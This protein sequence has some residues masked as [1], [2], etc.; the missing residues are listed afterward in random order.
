MK[1]FKKIITLGLS[2]VFVVAIAITS[3]VIFGNKNRNN[4]R[5]VS[6]VEESFNWQDYGVYFASAEEETGASTAPTTMK[7]GA[8]YIGPGVDFNVTAGTFSNHEA[9]Y[10]GAFFVDNGATLNIYGGTIKSNGAMY[11]GAIY[12][13]EGGTLNLYGGEIIYNNAQ[14][15][16]AIYVEANSTVV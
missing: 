1:K 10:G 11:G 8:I 2:L 4:E 13:A 14:E 9:Y 7:G 12:V 15:G 3:L 16:P 5:P 6:D